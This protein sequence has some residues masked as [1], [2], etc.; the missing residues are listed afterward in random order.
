LLQSIFR[1]YNGQA[2][3]MP[4]AVFFGGGIL[5]FHENL[6]YSDCQKNVPFAE[7]FFAASAYAAIL[8]IGTSLRQAV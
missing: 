5:D 3:G 8:L 2:G 6:L 1:L 4:P 7:G